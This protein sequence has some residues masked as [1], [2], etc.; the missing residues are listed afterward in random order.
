[1][2]YHIG[3]VEKIADVSLFC[4]N[5]ANFVPSFQNSVD[6]DLTISMNTVLNFLH[7]MALL[8]SNKQWL[9]DHLYL[10]TNILI[11]N[12]ARRGQFFEPAAQI[13]VNEPQQFLDM[14]SEE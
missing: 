9:A 2:P 6:M 14:L 1:M 10:D 13:E 4:K 3:K 7:S 8:T 5:I 12:L 11:D